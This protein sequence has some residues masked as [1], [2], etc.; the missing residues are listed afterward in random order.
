MPILS[1]PYHL[2]PGTT[3]IWDDLIII[4][5]ATVLVVVFTFAWN[6]WGRF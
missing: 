6:R 4:A 2:F 5:A 3:S 1:P